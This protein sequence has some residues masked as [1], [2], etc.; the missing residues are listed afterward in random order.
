[1]A[2]IIHFSNIN[3]NYSAYLASFYRDLVSSA[4]RLTSSMT[5]TVVINVGIAENDRKFVEAIFTEP[6]RD[7]ITQCFTVTSA[8]LPGSLR[9]PTHA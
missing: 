3:G 8:E 2:N 5:T 1:M 4:C 6:Q 7:G 9:P